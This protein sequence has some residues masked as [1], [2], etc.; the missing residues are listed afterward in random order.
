MR[1][2]IERLIIAERKLLG[3]AHLSGYRQGYEEGV[4]AIIKRLEA[5]L[6]LADEKSGSERKETRGN[7]VSEYK[8]GY[9]DGLDASANT[10]TDAIASEDIANSDG[11]H[12]A[13]IFR[14]EAKRVR[15]GE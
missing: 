10:L 4:I 8:R 11:E 2:E 15:G 12:F 14:A 3:N 7:G 6:A 9:A 1:E 5:I 13:K